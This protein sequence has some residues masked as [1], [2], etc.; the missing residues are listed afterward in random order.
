MANQKND[1]SNEGETFMVKRG[2]KEFKQMSEQY[3]DLVIDDLM[4]EEVENHEEQRYIPQI[5]MVQK[6]KAQQ[7]LD[8]DIKAIEIML[9]RASKAKEM[10][11][12][13][14]SNNEEGDEIGFEG[15]ESLLENDSEI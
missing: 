1:K 5:K 12:K 2:N 4:M 10:E 8:N 15:S 3:E 11:Q 6:S 14:D 7:Q 13:V 9:E